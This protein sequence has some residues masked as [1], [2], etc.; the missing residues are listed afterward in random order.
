M[1]EIRL[2]D[3]RRYEPLEKEKLKLEDRRFLLN[4]NHNEVLF[5]ESMLLQNRILLIAMFALFVATLSLIIG[6]EIISEKAKAIITTILTAFSFWI[7]FTFSNAIKRVKDQN[8]N[9][10]ANYETLFKH[11][12]NYA[13]K[14]PNKK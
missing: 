6:L 5:N 12:F 13:K 10:K 7:L 1:N 2:I 4:I 8:D 3:E 11:H 9:I 14:E